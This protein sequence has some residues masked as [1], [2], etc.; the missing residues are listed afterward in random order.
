MPELDEA[1]AV[2]R[3][4]NEAML[5]D[6][7]AA[8]L[9]KEQECDPG[10]IL[11]PTEEHWAEYSQLLHLRQIERR[12]QQAQTRILTRWQLHMGR[13]SSLELIATWKSHPR[14][15]FDREVLEG[16]PAP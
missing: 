2:A 7:A 4:W 12:A 15:R 3:E 8:E 13:A 10:L 1:I 6:L 5:P 9:L 16:V 11:E 14:L